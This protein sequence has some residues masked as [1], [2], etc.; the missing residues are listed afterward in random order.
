MRLSRERRCNSI[1]LLNEHK[2]ITPTENRQNPGR[3][4]GI[5]RVN[6][7]QE[8]WQG[9]D[10][11]TKT[12]FWWWTL[13]CGPLEWVKWLSSLRIA[14][15]NYRYLIQGCCHS[16]N[17]ASFI[18]RH[19]KILLRC[20]AVNTNSS[21]QVEKARRERLRCSRWTVYFDSWGSLADSRQQLWRPGTICMYSWKCCY[22]SSLQ[23][24]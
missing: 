23:K 7:S 12:K 9:T 3:Q 22:F 20:K 17:I 19:L 2:A 5:Y 18:W 6:H 15:S 16:I 14:F 1:A 11:R 8:I 4:S 21:C 24:C 10:A 13:T